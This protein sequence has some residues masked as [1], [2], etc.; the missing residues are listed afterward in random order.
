[1]SSA[2]FLKNEL[3]RE[4]AMNLIT[5]NALVVSEEELKAEEAAEAPAEASEETAE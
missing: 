3:L 4:Q 5:E 1:M 2:T